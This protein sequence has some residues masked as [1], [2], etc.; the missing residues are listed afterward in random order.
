METDDG[1]SIGIWEFPSLSA[2]DNGIGAIVLGSD[3]L[4]RFL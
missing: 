2:P 1:I 4:T 3:I